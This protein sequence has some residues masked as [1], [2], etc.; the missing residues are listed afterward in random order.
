MTPIITPTVIAGPRSLTRLATRPSVDAEYAVELPRFAG[1]KKPP[2]ATSKDA[3]QKAAQPKKSSK[4]WRLMKAMFWGTA[5]TAGY[6]GGSYTY[7][8]VNMHYQTQR[9]VNSSNV[10]FKYYAAD[11]NGQ[12]K[13]QFLNFNLMKVK[14]EVAFKIMEV[15]QDRP[16]IREALM[17]VPG[18]LEIRL[19]QADALTR[20][21]NNTR[22]GKDGDHAHVGIAEIDK[23]GKVSMEFATRVVEN[24]LELSSKGNDVVAHELTHILD[25][26]ELLRNGQAHVIGADGF[27]PGWSNSEKREYVDARAEE[28]AKIQVGRSPMDRYALTND[29]EFLAVLSETFFEKPNEL[30]ESNPTLYR[31]MQRFFDLDPASSTTWSAVKGTVTGDFTIDYISKRDPSP[32]LYILGGMAI[33]IGGGIIL[34]GRRKKKD[35]NA[36]ISP[37]E[38]LDKEFDVEKFMR[39]GK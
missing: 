38:L 9:F 4:L 10:T 16:D 8:Y 37:K 34:V 29:K 14:H 30:K 39:E 24:N 12:F 15:L 19:Y 1:E 11:A 7:N 5:L 28:M 22:V 26:L 3:A 25:Y 21:G 35:P 6:A 33:L 20:E 2:A 13:E 27:L 31:M 17:N 36:P 18:G 23:K 32:K